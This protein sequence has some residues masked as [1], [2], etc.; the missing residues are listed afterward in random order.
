MGLEIFRVL[1]VGGIAL[2]RGASE[3]VER[4]RFC[5][6]TEQAI[7]KYFPAPNS[8]GASGFDSAFFF[9]RRFAVENC[10]VAEG[11]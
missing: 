3:E 4:E 8:R 2:I 1:K 9:R 11:G 10:A 5:P 7:D 6:V